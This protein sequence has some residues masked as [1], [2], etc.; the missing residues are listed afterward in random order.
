MPDASQTPAA[1]WPDFF[2]QQL[3]QD[4]AKTFDIDELSAKFAAELA[5]P[6]PLAQS[7]CALYQPLAAHCASARGKGTYV[8]GVNGAQGTGKSTA[9]S[10]LKVLLEAV[11]GLNVCALSIDD[12]Y[13]SRA[14]RAELARDTH[15]LLATRG[16]PGTHNLPLALETFT[17]LKKA[18]AQQL[19]PIP[20]FDKSQDDCVSRELWDTVQGRPD[21]IIFEGWCVGAR[22]QR[23]SDLQTPINALE[24]EEDIDGHWRRYVN[25][26]LADYQALFAQIDLL[27]MLKAPSFTQVLEW[28][29]LQEQK[30]RDSLTDAQLQHSRVMSAAQ[31]ERFIAH[32]ERL[33]RWM[34]S[35]MPA[36]ANIVLEL[37]EN[38]QV[39][40]IQCHI[41]H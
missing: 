7:L 27:V 41:N 19:T 1:L 13:L 6:E 10:I 8:V 40:A 28:R 16:V 11:Y 9:A 18:G 29:Q 37:A 4:A 15:P 26:A 23:S 38:H 39:A 14:A 24:K 34:L 17:Q 12:L 30:L 35:E 22:A 36:R 3:R 21:I 33:T 32:Y 25:D 2:T 20:R 5:L 31:I